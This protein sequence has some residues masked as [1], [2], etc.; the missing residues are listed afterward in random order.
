MKNNKDEEIE[1]KLLLFW[2]VYY[3]DKSLSLR[4]GRSS[5]IQDWDINVPDLITHAPDG[6]MGYHFYHL[7]SRTARVQGQIYEHLYSPECMTQPDHVRTF[8]VDALVKELKEI[9]VHAADVEVSLSSTFRG[10]VI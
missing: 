3:L 2:S 6:P 5:S 8:R 4:L 1:H 9:T 10:A 7:W